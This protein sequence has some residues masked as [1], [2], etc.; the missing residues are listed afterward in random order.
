MAWQMETQDSTLRGRLPEW[1][2]VLLYPVFAFAL[3]LPTL[4]GSPPSSPAC[5]TAARVA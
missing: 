4:R 3:G 2:A 5:V 1:L